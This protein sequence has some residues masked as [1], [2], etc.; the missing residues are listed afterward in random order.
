M[1]W[2]RPV[3]IVCSAERGDIEVTALLPVLTA[4]HGQAMPGD[5]S[6]ETKH[7]CIFSA[8]IS[9]SVL[10]LPVLLAQVAAV[11]GMCLFVI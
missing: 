4:H 3:A 2:T 7:S 5:R 10:H 9:C 11:L 6:T 1:V 8:H